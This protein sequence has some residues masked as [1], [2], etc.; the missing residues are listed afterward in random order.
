VLGLLSPGG[1]PARV[2]MVY[3]VQTLGQLLS[4]GYVAIVID[5]KGKKKAP[6][7]VASN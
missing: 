4:E 5:L 6:V 3:D 2:V 1:G 7:Q